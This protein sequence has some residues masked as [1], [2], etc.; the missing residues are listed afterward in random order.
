MENNIQILLLKESPVCKENIIEISLRLN[1]E[2]YNGLV[3]KQ[4][5]ILNEVLNNE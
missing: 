2:L 5:K 3:I 1:G 4:E